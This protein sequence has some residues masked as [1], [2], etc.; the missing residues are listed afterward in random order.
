MTAID[1][2]IVGLTVL[3]VVWGFW[4]GLTVGTLALAGFG[5]GAVAG[6]RLAPLVLEGG[7]HSTYA[8][9]LAF[10]GAL[11]LGALVAALV[12]KVGI[13]YRRRLDR[14]G[15]AD[16]IGGALLAGCLGLVAAWFI[17]AVA[18]QVKRLEDPVERS[19][20]L[21]RLNA[22]LPP[23]G[24]LLVSDAPAPDAQSPTIE[25]P[26]TELSP[27]SPKL[28]R[29]KEIRLAGRSVV[30]IG[31]LA[32]DD[33]TPG[34][35]WIAADGIVVTNAHVVAGEKR[36]R[37]RLEGK[38]PSYAATPVLFD[39]V[40]DLALLKVPGL[41]GF[42]PLVL[43]RRPRA[44]TPA[45][46]LGFPNGQKKVRPGRLGVNSSKRPGRLGRRPFG[47]PD[48]LSGQPNAYFGAMAPR[49]ATGGPVV[50]RSGQVLTTIFARYGRGSLGIP[51][52]IVRRA[53]DRKQRKAD[54]GKCRDSA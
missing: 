20:I 14:L 24:P 53:L 28:A 38:G 34:S 43:R 47:F 29:D 15:P 36:I 21:R 49:G 9:F 48:E 12:E 44:G 10:P 6:S 26:T 1:F 8:P 51:N 52:P 33:G 17:A 35:G 41:R 25:G 16:G 31:V 7:L 27:V 13:R 50:D 32:C 22:A 5:A 4:R 2:A 11:I 37:L 45:A 3:A 54:T 39:R 30:K 18:V 42:D 19:H 46:L 40:N 23:P